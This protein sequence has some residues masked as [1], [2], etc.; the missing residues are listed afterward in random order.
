MQFRASSAARLALCPGSGKAEAGLPDRTNADAAR[1]ERIHEWLA[2]KTMGYATPELAPDELEVAEKLYALAEPMWP[3]PGLPGV[4][5]FAEQPMALGCWS[6]HAD[7]LH[8]SEMDITVTDW[9]TGWGDVP[10]AD[11]NAQ[12]RVYACLASRYYGRPTVRA[13]LV[14][15]QGATQVVYGRPDLDMAEHELAEIAEAAMRQDAQRIP[16]DR[17]CCYCRAF[18]HPDACPE[19]C[20][21]PV[22]AQS[23]LPSVEERIKALTKPDLDK[24]CE[25]L[26]LCERLRDLYRDELRRRLEADPAA[27]DAYKLEA[28]SMRR[29]VENVSEAWLRIP[30]AV[31]F[32][33]CSVSIADMEKAYARN[34]GIK[35]KAARLQLE[36]ALGN[37]ILSKPT[38]RSL[39][40]KD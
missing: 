36:K 25:L 33:G 13:L 1:G 19:S 7:V 22:Q 14:T 40:R 10:D 31:F 17:A 30:D 9:K 38:K 18:G 37:L 27:S 16:A 8:I 32:A 21:L 5:R 3:A 28:P 34:A 4:M 35:R 20:R 6:G 26:D 24:A 2:K 15:P 39:V 23:V 11:C 29:E 12:L